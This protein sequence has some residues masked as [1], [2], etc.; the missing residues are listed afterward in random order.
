MGL[1][2]NCAPDIPEFWHRTAFARFFDHCAFSCRV[3]AAKAKSGKI[4]GAALDS[5]GLSAAETL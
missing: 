3:R 2:T 1:V 5:L 4:T